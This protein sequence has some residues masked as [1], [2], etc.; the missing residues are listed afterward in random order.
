MEYAVTNHTFTKEIQK[1]QNINDLQKYACLKLDIFRKQPAD[2]ID[3]IHRELRDIYEGEYAGLDKDERYL[4]YYAMCEHIL[5]HY[6]RDLLVN[7][8]VNATKGKDYTILIHK[9]KERSFPTQ[10]IID[11]C[12]D[13]LKG[14]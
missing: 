7:T 11:V 6:P 2:I 4:I 8:L 10:I 14:K 12:V 5:I 9:I 3:E 1:M 13:I